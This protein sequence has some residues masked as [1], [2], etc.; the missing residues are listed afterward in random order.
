[1]PS[2]VE[3]RRLKRAARREKQRQGNI[4]RAAKMHAA[5]MEREESDE[6]P[7]HAGT[8]MVTA[9]ICI[10]AVQDGFTG[11]GAALFTR[12]SYQRAA[13]LNTMQAVSRPWN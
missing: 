9:G 3:E 11:T 2:T 12:L 5:R 10:L 13:G 8:T 6:T 4:G 1:M 7:H